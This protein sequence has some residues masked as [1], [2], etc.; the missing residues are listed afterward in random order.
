MVVVLFI[1]VLLICVLVHEWGHFIVAKKSGM[2]VEEFGF[3]IPPRLWSFK[4]G[5]TKYSIKALPIGG[6]VKIAG[7]NGQ[8][9][10][11]PFERQFESKS[12]YKKSAVLLA[13]VCM[14]LVLALV[15]FSVAYMIGLPGVV[16]EGGTPTVLSVV[17]KSPVALAG[18]TT[19]DTIT[20]V[21]VGDTKVED[22]RTESLHDAI[23]HSTK[24]V[25]ITYE[26]G[27]MSKQAVI[28]PTS[29]RTIGVS[30][31]SLGVVR[32]SFFK[33]VMH[34]GTHVWSL[35]KSIAHAIGELVGRVIHGAPSAQ[36][37]IGPVGL[38]R[39]IGSASTFGFAYLLAFI[40]M[41]SVNLAVLNVMPFP[42][43]DGGRLIVVWGEALTGRKFSPMTIG[44]I[45]TIGFLVLIGLMV[46]LT[47]GDIKKA[48]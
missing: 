21:F 36:G 28:T 26:H 38:A 25:V 4:K 27:G 24:D 23:V 34:A 46:A 13:G 15:L 19:G 17:E 5:E 32:L 7:E 31:E 40:A 22:V 3:G 18:I 2:L 35:T 44:L 11:V 1:V 20:S 41:I 47:V 33:A 39:E 14:N 16:D 8:E 48:L 6:F 43:L 45:H 30:I 12:W 29:E 10:G 9:S 37:L 42:A